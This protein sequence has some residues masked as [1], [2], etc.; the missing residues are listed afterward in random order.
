[1]YEIEKNIP[2][3]TDRHR[4]GRGKPIYPFAKMEVGDSFFV[5]L[6]EGAV[7]NKFRTRIYLGAR[8]HKEVHNPDF[9]ITVKAYP[10]GFR[11]WRLK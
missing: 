10:G 1:M 7:P 11:C 3:P 9:Q 6:P 8:R 2:I 5:P 4:G